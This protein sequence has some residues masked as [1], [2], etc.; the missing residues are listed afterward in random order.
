MKWQEGTGTAREAVT[1]CAQICTNLRTIDVTEI[2][3]FERLFLVSG[4]GTFVLCVN[5][6]YAST[7]LTV[8]ARSYG[9]IL[10]L[11]FQ[12]RYALPKCYVSRLYG[13]RLKYTCKLSEN[14]STNVCVSYGHNE[15][16]CFTY[17]GSCTL[18]GCYMSAFCMLLVII[19][20]ICRKRSRSIL[21]MVQVR[22]PGR[23]SNLVKNMLTLFFEGPPPGNFCLKTS[24]LSRNS[25]LAQ[26]KRPGR[27]GLL[28]TCVEKVSPTNHVDCIS[29]VYG[30]IMHCGAGLRTTVTLILSQLKWLPRWTWGEKCSKIP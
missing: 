19:D 12:G 23:C 15:N 2:I 24:P 18:I 22:G 10:K 29:L 28:W 6:S 7:T 30:N 25:S 13:V 9:A 11:I 4:V 26:R 27:E 16:W 21:I 5:C 17:V 20:Q 8:Q 3:F 1:N 14:S